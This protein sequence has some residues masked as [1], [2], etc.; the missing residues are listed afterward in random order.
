MR[1]AFQRKEA[2]LGWQICS[3]GHANREE[4]QTPA[5]SRLGPNSWNWPKQPLPRLRAESSVFN[6]WSKFIQWKIYILKLVSMMK[7]QPS[8]LCRFVSKKY[9]VLVA[10]KNPQRC[11]TMEASCLLPLLGGLQRLQTPMPL[12]MPRET[13]TWMKSFHSWGKTVWLEQSSSFP[14]SFLRAPMQ[15]VGADPQ[16]WILTHFFSVSSL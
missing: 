6:I 9:C 12:A 14:S 4:H 16:V 15:W 1:H 11:L 3:Q 5:L 7:F 8:D 13:S 2:L 10:E